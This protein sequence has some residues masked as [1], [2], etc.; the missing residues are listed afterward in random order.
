M[1]NK[2][3]SQIYKVYI[4]VYKVYCEKQQPKLRVT[5]MSV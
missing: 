2:K 5:H 4:V 3:P 1:F